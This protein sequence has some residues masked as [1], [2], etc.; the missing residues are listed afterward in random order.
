MKK[1]NFVNEFIN[2]LPIYRKI[3]FNRL[4]NLYNLPET[5]DILFCIEDTIDLL[6][7][8]NIFKISLSNYQEITKADCRAFKKDF[9]ESEYYYNKDI[10]KSIII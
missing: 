8:I 9:K 3:L 5:Q 2:E 1:D 4:E 6:N 10:L 7:D